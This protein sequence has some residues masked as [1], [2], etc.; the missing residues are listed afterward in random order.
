M[1]EMTYSQTLAVVHCWCGIAVGIPSNL[2]RVMLD[3][4]KSCY[5]PQGHTFVFVDTYKDRLA[6]K[7]RELAD[8]RRR[9]Q[10]ARELLEAEERSH[11]ATRG[12][13]TRHKKRASAGVCPC[14]NRTFQQL[15][16]HMKTKHPDYI[17]AA[18]S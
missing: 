15:A 18:K 4:G 8:E 13:L 16:R 12:H 2:R 14:C 6:K 10:A 1:T 17:A 7:E 9:R 5:C 11:A 3:E